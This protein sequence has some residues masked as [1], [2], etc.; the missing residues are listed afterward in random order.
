MN[1][2]NHFIKRIEFDFEVEDK[3]RAKDTQDTLSRLFRSD[4]QRIIEQVLDEFQ[5]EGHL[6][7]ITNLELDLG[8][9]S[10][11][12]LE[13][14]LIDRLRSVLRRKMDEIR[15]RVT[16]AASYFHHNEVLIPL[17][18]AKMEV[19]IYFLKHGRLPVH[20][21]KFP[22]RI[23]DI[24]RELIIEDAQRVKKAIGPVIRN[25]PAVAKR[26]V[27][28]F[29]PEMTSELIK[30]FNESY[31]GFIEREIKE[32]SFK[33][34]E[35]YR[36][37]QPQIQKLLQEA[38]LVFLAMK[39]GG[40]FNQ[41]EYFQ[42]IK[43]FTERE[44]SEDLEKGFPLEGSS[45]SVTSLDQKY[46]S[47]I[48]S[49]KGA[50]SKG[51]STAKKTELVSAF[52]TL[53]RFHPQALKEIF[54]ELG[55]QKKVFQSFSEIL[56]TESIR[57]FIA[58]ISPASSRVLLRIALRAIAAH[59][60][61]LRGTK[62]ETKFRNET[63]AALLQFV[64]QTRPAL[65]SGKSFVSFLKEAVEKDDIAP[66][67]L[68]ESWTPIIEEG[69]T[70][71]ELDVQGFKGENIEQTE[72]ETER[73]K[74]IQEQ[75]EKAKA[76]AEVKA[77]AEE[78][79]EEEA[80]QEAAAVQ[81]TAEAEG[82]AIEEAEAIVEA[83]E[84]ARII[85]EQEKEES[86]LQAEE[87]ANLEAENEAKLQ[88]EKAEKE[89]EDSS[90]QAEEDVEGELKDDEV[91]QEEKDVSEE[92]ANAKEEEQN[93]NLS[94]ESEED[95]PTTDQD[96]IEVQ[97][98]DK[99]EE[100][101][102]IELDKG[103][104]KAKSEEEVQKGDTERAQLDFV[105]YVLER[106]EIPWWSKDLDEPDPAKALMALI[107]AK[108]EALPFEL[109]Q[110]VR[111][112]VAP[113]KAR[114]AATLLDKF[115]PEAF[116]ALLAFVI[117]ET[118][119]FFVSLSLLLLRLHSEINPENFL[120]K[121]RD[122][123]TFQWYPIVRFYL[124]YIETNPGPQESVKY[125][126]K[127]LEATSTMESSHII[128]ALK[129][130]VDKAVAAGEM[131]FFPFQTMLPRPDE[132][133]RL[134]SNI[135]QSAIQF[136]EQT[137]RSIQAKIEERARK[138][139][140]KKEEEEAQAAIDGLVNEVE[141]VETIDSKPISKDG[142]SSETED[143]TDTADLPTSELEGLD[144]SLEEGVTTNPAGEIAEVKGEVSDLTKD[145]RE[146]TEEGK[147]KEEARSK[148]E[149]IEAEKLK[150][151]DPTV[152]EAMDEVV[153]EQGQLEAGYD[154]KE[155]EIEESSNP[156]QEVGME[157]KGQTVKDSEAISEE[158]HA[159]EPVKT[160]QTEKSL[161]TEGT[162]QAEKT[163]EI[164]KT[165]QAEKTE[166][167]D[168]S[169]KTEV[170]EQ[171]GKTEKELEEQIRLENAQ[172]D[173]KRE[174]ADQEPDSIRDDLEALPSQED[175]ELGSE[176]AEPEGQ[177]VSTSQDSIEKA[178]TLP[179]LESA[180][181]T[182]E[183]EKAFEEK[184]AIT[185]GIPE[186]GEP[187]KG[188]GDSLT[189][190]E[191]KAFKEI[192]ALQIE[193]EESRSQ[194]KEISEASTEEAS[195]ERPE[196]TQLPTEN[197]DEAPAP[198]PPL[199]PE[200]Q[201]EIEQ[202]LQEAKTSAEQVVLYYLRVGSLPPK[203]LQLK[204]KALFAMIREVITSNPTKV[205]A[206]LRQQAR[207]TS[208]LRRIA[209]LPEEVYEMMVGVLVPPSQKEQFVRYFRA[210]RNLFISTQVP[211]PVERIAAQAF[212][213]LLENNKAQLQLEGYIKSLLTFLSQES[214][215]SEEKLIVWMLE[216]VERRPSLVKV[217]LLEVLKAIRTD[218][219]TPLDTL[220]ATSKIQDVNEEE[221]TIT[222]K[223]SE[224]K[225]EPETY[226]NNAGLILFAPL[227]KETFLKLGYID[228]TGKFKVDTM[229]ERAVHFLGYLAYEQPRM[230]EEEMVL[231]KLMV[232]ME[233]DKPLA[234]EFKLTES[235]IKMTSTLIDLIRSKWMGMEKS[236]N[237]IFRKSWLMREG[238]L[239][240]DNREDYVLRVDQKGYDVLLG[241]LSIGIPRFEYPW[242]STTM[243][244]EWH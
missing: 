38:S 139:E 70:L 210:I 71:E 90:R 124:D 92:E 42:S 91:T 29:V 85:E 170:T 181:E 18:S 68:I 95:I 61:F 239:Q 65:Q 20:A 193:M 186:L 235:E 100:S 180:A 45:T 62:S 93:K 195:D 160:E 24:L 218:K 206:T 237:V 12:Y 51:I 126:V 149:E 88:E 133:I 97:D 216:E 108:S 238:R 227:L 101:P 15:A 60:R 220:P 159:S 179:G 148:E 110:R 107:E 64:T 27:E 177:E 123:E 141:G 32:I 120:A 25:Q 14:D 6:L 161:K 136:E 130:V 209:S 50:V 166:Q 205:E 204:E 132:D 217:T 154:S 117:P 229:R 84:E 57:R 53:L 49:I 106:N 221:I 1:S 4:L 151:V 83:E 207:S 187:E 165:D 178:T 244:V 19:V 213:F 199:K 9:L 144:E 197:L 223:E 113:A 215:Q 122:A 214:S 192:E 188:S 203:V 142:I 114:M 30:M 202:I 127:M 34:Q 112:A 208:V 191:L 143:E 35:E 105:L 72:I 7:R 137:M 201:S 189:P 183:E 233:L 31:Q 145:D 121:V 171:A 102:E 228:P 196:E 36:F 135:A 232:G 33:V 234:L 174:A 28:Q 115:G 236:N 11:A 16:Y 77:E 224:T 47:L 147:Q 198:L 73:L 185:E 8:E 104:E 156:S 76:E 37:S 40:A 212:G 184:D 52:E 211:M 172:N 240:K 89:L 129:T 168:K 242:T 10:E 116:Q 59:G 39:E 125:A 231:C 74:E 138:E 230:P 67:Q 226:I 58:Q 23:E 131:R 22:G 167:T 21:T 56:P 80:A 150:S 219:E 78:L 99:V 155:E 200:L 103:E 48:Q 190:D 87:L 69:T 173:L 75:E 17:W 55:S 169:L 94:E 63:Y 13:S 140:E 176:K 109:K 2:D 146:L 82:Q 81:A 3:E 243:R 128:A 86:L 43:R 46:A 41:A 119:G 222:P 182:E 96:K 225:P 152:G 134:S 44:V 26:I 175:S 164:E 194:E 98:P 79:T 157:E 66:P 153:Q 158:E 163:E 162:E 54:Q 111:Q 241:R 5:V 118:S